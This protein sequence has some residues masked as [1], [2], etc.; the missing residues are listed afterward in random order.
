MLNRFPLFLSSGEKKRL[1]LLSML[2]LNGDFLLFDEPDL[3]LDFKGQQDFVKVVHLLKK[4]GKSIIIATHD[5]SFLVN[6][7]LCDRVL[8]LKDGNLIL[9]KKINSLKQNFVFY[10]FL[11]N[12]GIKLPLI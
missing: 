9:D 6:N 4:R 2:I 11:R 8:V 1:T 5:L 10:V 3:G 12:I 7:N